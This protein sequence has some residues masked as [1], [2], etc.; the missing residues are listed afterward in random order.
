[1]LA[2]Y[3]RHG[4][5]KLS[6]FGISAEATSRNARTSRYSQ[7]TSCYRAPEL[8]RLPATYTNKSDLWALGCVIYEMST[9]GTAFG[10]DWDV[11]QYDVSESALP[12]EPHAWVNEFWRQ[13][14]RDIIL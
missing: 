5:W 6:D 8:L 10:G 7:G 2:L 9:S 11:H 12:Y 3:S 14:V 1:M 13:T 4:Q